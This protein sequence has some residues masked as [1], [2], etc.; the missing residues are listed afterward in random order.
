MLVLLLTTALTLPVSAAPQDTRAPVIEPAAAP[1]PAPAEEERWSFLFSLFHFDPPDEDAYTSLIGYADRGP[2]HL[3]ARYQ[4]EALDSVS[5]FAGHRF[6]WEGEVGVELVPMLGFIGGDLD[7]VAPALT[8]DMTWKKVEWYVESEYVFDFDDDG[9]DYFYAWSELTYGLTDWMRLGLVAQ[10]T[11]IYD[12]ELEV[13]RGLLLQLSSG[14]LGASAYWFNP[15][16]DDPYFAVSFG[17][18]F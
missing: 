5:L 8:V 17:V 18:G 4:Y 10:R 15:D 3:E 9:D 2:W 7:G 13:D 6:A 12:Q 11:R 16:Q 14:L 1:E